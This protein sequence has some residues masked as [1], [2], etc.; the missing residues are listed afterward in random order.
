MKSKLIGGVVLAA[1]LA[2]T[3]SGCGA[4]GNGG[5][6]GE[7]GGDDLI[8]VGFAQTGSESGWRAANT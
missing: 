5:G 6:G 2:L 8:T 4:G 7:G 1:T 3:M